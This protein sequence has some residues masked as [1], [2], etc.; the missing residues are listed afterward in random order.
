M[1]VGGKPILKVKSA[2]GKLELEWLC[3]EWEHWQDLQQSGEFIGMVA[4]CR[5]DLAAAHERQHKGLGKG[6]PQLT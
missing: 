1:E 5:E 3:A 4:K 2:D 6:K